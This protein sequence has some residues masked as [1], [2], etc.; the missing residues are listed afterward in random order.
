M[1]AFQRQ[2]HEIT[3]TTMAQSESYESDRKIALELAKVIETPH[4]ENTF[5]IS[6]HNPQRQA[7]T[8]KD[9]KV[10]PSEK[11]PQLKRIKTIS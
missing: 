10:R 7:P 8:T 11:E 5:A 1:N 9:E 6:A 3:L 4:C 2:I